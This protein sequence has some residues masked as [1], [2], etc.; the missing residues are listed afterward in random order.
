MRQLRAYL[1]DVLPLIV[2]L[3]LGVLGMYCVHAVQ[4]Y[5]GAPPR[6]LAGVIFMGIVFGIYV[7][8]RFTDITEDFAND[9]GKY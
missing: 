9:I 4:L 5:I 8:N 3:Y 6:I 2:I 7:L 1:N